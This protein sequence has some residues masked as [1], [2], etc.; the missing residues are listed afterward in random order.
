MR[1][2]VVLTNAQKLAIRQ[3][4]L[5]TKTLLR[6]C[7]KLV[8][9]DYPTEV[10]ERMFADEDFLRMCFRVTEQIYGVLGLA[11]PSRTNPKSQLP[12]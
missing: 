9:K 11:L 6:E 12:N 7:R 4:V 2:R 10:H 3:S 5:L 8:Q 1:L